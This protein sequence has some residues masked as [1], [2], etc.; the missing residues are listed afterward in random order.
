MDK[1]EAEKLISIYAS[2]EMANRG[3]C[4]HC[5]SDLFLDIK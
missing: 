1:C 4:Q 5:G 2:P 3:F